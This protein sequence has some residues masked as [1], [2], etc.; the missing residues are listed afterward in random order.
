MVREASRMNAEREGTKCR[1]QNSRHKSQQLRQ[2]RRLYP[3]G[4]IARK[5][6]NPIKPAQKSDKRSNTHHIEDEEAAQCSASRLQL[7]LL[8]PQHPVQGSPKLTKNVGW[9]QFWHGIASPS[10]PRALERR[11]RDAVV[12]DARP[13]VPRPCSRSRRPVVRLIQEP[14]SPLRQE[15]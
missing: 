5:C 4:N 15:L 8:L 13:G 2:L 6:K 7:H 1:P 10:S 3:S 11:P 14:P 12:L 9:S